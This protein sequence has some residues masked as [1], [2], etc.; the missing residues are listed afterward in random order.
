LKAEKLYNLIAELDTSVSKQILHK[1]K[2]REDKRLKILASLI[3]YRNADYS[4]F[5]DRFFNLCKSSYKGESEE[6]IKHSMRRLAD[7]FCNEIEGIILISNAFNDGIG[8]QLLA[9]YYRAKGNVFLSEYYYEKTYKKQ[10]ASGDNFG[11]INTIPPLIS[12]NYVKS[13]KEG[14]LRGLE[15]NEL[16]LDMTKDFYH[17]SHVDYY[18]SLTNLYFEDYRLMPKSVTQLNAE[19]EGLVNNTENK[20][21]VLGYRISQMRLSF[22]N[23]NL[24]VYD[25]SIDL[26]VDELKK[27]KDKDP[28]IRKYYFFRLVLGFY[29]GS[30]VATLISIAE[31]IRQINRLENFVDNYTVFYMSILMVLSGDRAGFAQLLKEEKLCFKQHFSYLKIFIDG[32]LYYIDGEYVKSQ[33]KLNQI[34]DADDY[35][36]SQM[37]RIFLISIYFGT[38]ENE[39]LLSLVRSTERQIKKHP[40][41]FLINE[42]ASTLLKIYR[43]MNLKKSSGNVDLTKGKLSIVHKFLLL[44]DF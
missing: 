3:R 22:R 31:K 11:L 10:I 35:F 18:N 26:L 4:D 9:K 29:V 28:L 16:M 21:H 13:T 34:I 36:V 17:E 6:K 5:I 32:L 25:K 30:D 7:Y 1:C 2:I 40:E 19:I 8:Y 27:A 41:K 37:A 39:L 23:G 43:K 12:L 24:E 42:S 14:F 44:R 15:L 33:K 20:R 38:G